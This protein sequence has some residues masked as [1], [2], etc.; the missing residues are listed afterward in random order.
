MYDSS[1]KFT[2]PIALGGFVGAQVNALLGNRLGFLGT[3]VDTPFQVDMVGEA[4][5]EAMED[6][7]VRGAV[8][9]KRMEALA[10]KAWRKSML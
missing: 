2:M 7:T 5:V 9:T 8:G 4:V 3:M 1:R 10:T 6:E